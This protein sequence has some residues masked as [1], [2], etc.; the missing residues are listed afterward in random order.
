VAAT[1][2]TVDVLGRLALFADLSLPDLEAVAHTLGEA[3]FPPDTRVLRRDLSGAA[4]YVIR[5]GEAS[6]QIDGRELARLGRGDFFGEIS[7]LTGQP[8]AADVI[9]TTLLRCFTLPGSDVEQF[10]IARP[11][12]MLRMLQAEARRLRVAN[13]WRG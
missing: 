9:A 3:A 8:P 13:T 12:V 6:V 2:D 4:F 7:V 1:D 5:D 11:T 10:L